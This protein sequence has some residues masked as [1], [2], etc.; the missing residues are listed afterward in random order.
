MNSANPDKS[1]ILFLPDIG[2]SSEMWMNVANHYK[3]QYNCVLIDF[4][5]FANTPAINDYYTKQYVE[6][7]ESYVKQQ[8][9][10]NLILFG[11]NFGG[12]IACQLA[13]NK[14]INIRKIITTD[15]FP[16]Q[17]LVHEQKYKPNKIP[18]IIQ[19]LKEIYC[20]APLKDFI[21]FQRKIIHTIYTNDKML[22]EKILSWQLASDRKTIINVLINQLTTD[23]YPY[24]KNNEIPWLNF[25]VGRTFEKK[26][27]I[28]TLERY[29]NSKNISQITTHHSKT[30]F[31]IDNENW[32]IKKTKKFINN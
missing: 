32:F 19:Q 14:K 21:A 9:W 22:A 26:A 12:F 2:C 30:F 17:R 4:A 25:N 3:E 31:F 8:N 10:S 1:T 11:H 13:A 24:L 6:E 28:H 5:G 20:Y 7:I 15:F 16:N 23:L 18:E 27:E 29:I